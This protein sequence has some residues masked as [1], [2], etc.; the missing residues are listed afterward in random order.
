MR[1]KYMTARSRRAYLQQPTGRFRGGKLIPVQAVPFEQSEGGIV[2]QNIEIELDPVVGRLISEV[3][4]EV[5]CVFVPSLAMEA[6][7][8]PNADFPGNEEAYRAKLISGE[9]IFSLENEN[10][11][12]KRL[13]IEPISIDGVKK[14]SETVRLAHNVA[15]NYLRQRKYVKATLLDNTNQAMTP[16]LLSDTILSRFS[17]VLD[18]EDRI[19]GAVRLE[20]S[21]P[22]RG[23]G[24]HLPQAP[25]PTLTTQTDI[26]VQNNVGWMQNYGGPS[27]QAYIHIDQDPDNG[28]NPNI[29][30]H[31]DTENGQSL[32]LQ[33]FYQAERMDAFV[34]E[35][36]RVVDANPQYG[37]QIVNNMVHGLSVDTGKEPFLMYQKE[38]ILGQ[39]LR[40]AMDGPNLD[41][42]Q[43]DVDGTMSFAVPV[44]QTEFGGV[45]MTFITVKPDERLRS[46]PHPVFTKVWTGRNFVKDELAVDPVPVTMRDIDGECDQ[47]DENTTVFYTANN[48]LSRRYIDYGFNRHMDPTTVQNKSSIWAL[49][50]PVSVT[51]DNILYPDD[52][53]HYPWPIQDAEIAQYTVT[54]AVAVQ[55]PIIY[56]PTPVEELAIIETE[57]VFDD[58]D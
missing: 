12:T 27:G 50:I 2:Q 43:T 37:E 6:H 9:P 7:K 3:T 58:I 16:A 14:V 21:I 35:M 54:S 32:S 8:N 33:Q 44:P 30:A 31:F 39:N 28:G 10:E 22:V 46:Q 41:L 42:D 53:P 52:L 56:G 4:A 11:I 55:S 36:R 26:G 48:E 40:T 1:T 45:V 23:I 18:P 19:N 34:R 25:A 5:F 15:V 51:P 20:G 17:G 29:R 47:A 49:E 38:V 13:K 24:I 57:G